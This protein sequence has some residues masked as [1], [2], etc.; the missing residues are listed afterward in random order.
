MRLRS[1]ALSRLLIS[2]RTGLRSQGA[3]WEVSL[4]GGRLRVTAS[5]SDFRRFGPVA[6]VV[7]H[8]PFK[9]RVAGSSPA[10]LTK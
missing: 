3:P 7:E 4:R 8:V 2:A 10:R 6:Q 1:V 5:S 9:H